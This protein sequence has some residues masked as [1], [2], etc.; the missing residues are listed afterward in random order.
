MKSIISFLTIT[1]PLSVMAQEGYTFNSPFSNQEIDSLP[2]FIETITNSLVIPIGS[3]IVVMMIIWAGFLF[4]TAQGNESKLA[5]AKKAFTYSIIGAL[6]LL[7]AWV[8]ANALVG[9][10]C[11]LY[12]SDSPIGLCN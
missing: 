10:V 8:I 9:T 12:G 4:V 5:D 2:E 6:I 1:L 7:G 3:V 11:L